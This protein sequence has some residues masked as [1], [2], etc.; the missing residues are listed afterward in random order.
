MCTFSRLSPPSLP[1]KPRA[2]GASCQG[3]AAPSGPHRP[4]KLYA[5][6]RAT[7]R[8]WRIERGGLGAAVPPLG[9]RAGRARGV[10]KCC[11]R[12]PA[13][14]KGRQELQFVSECFSLFPILPPAPQRAATL[15]RVASKGRPAVAPAGA[16][17]PMGARRRSEIRSV[18]IRSLSGFVRYC[19]GLFGPQLRSETYGGIS[20][21]F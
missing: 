8:G 16:P 9:R 19:S 14:R 13:R 4:A 12:L 17:R 15:G 5:S 21:I 10:A 3:A 6:A 7:M 20:E 18:G 1:P 2:G 11:N